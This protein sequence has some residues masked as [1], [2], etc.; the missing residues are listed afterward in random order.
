VAGAHAAALALGN[1]TRSRSGCTRT[2]VADRRAR[3]QV[4]AYRRLLQA[5]DAVERR[6]D[7]G[8]AEL[9]AG[10]IELRAPLCDHGLRLR[11]SSIAS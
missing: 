2:S 11:T 5:H 1:G 7:H 6:D 10:Q 3:R 9:L 8:V 4:L